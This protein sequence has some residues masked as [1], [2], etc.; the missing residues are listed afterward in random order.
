MI[1][2]P[3]YKKIISKLFIIA[4]YNYLHLTT[5][6][7]NYVN[8]NQLALWKNVSIVHPFKTGK[9]STDIRKKSCI[10]KNKVTKSIV[11]RIVYESDKLWYISL[12]KFKYYALKYQMFWMF[13]Y[14]L[15]MVRGL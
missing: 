8:K 9:L 2:L 1:H 10:F 5:F 13:P 14:Y 3:N 7:I 12:N 6:I 15:T 4:G 11:K